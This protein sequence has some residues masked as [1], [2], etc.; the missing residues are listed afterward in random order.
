[1]LDRLC[2]QYCHQKTLP[3]HARRCGVI[4]KQSKERR[5]H[6]EEVKD[7]Y[8]QPGVNPLSDRAIAE[9]LEQSTATISIL[10]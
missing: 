7:C 2:N 3:Q 6:E 4:M 1:M 8:N 9:D 10:Q 5:T